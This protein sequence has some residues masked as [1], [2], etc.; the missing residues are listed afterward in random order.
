MRVVV[1]LGGNALEGGAGR[2]SGDGLG[3]AATHVADLVLD[4]HQVIVTH[5]NGPQVGE[6]LLDQ[7]AREP[8]RRRRL[9]LDVL[10]AM[11]QAQLG[12]LLQRDIEDELVSRGDHTDVVTVVTEVVVDEHDPAFV[13]PTKPVGP[14]LGAR[15]AGTHADTRWEDGWWRR[16]VPSPEPVHLVEHA[17]LRAIVED[18]I[19][20]ICAGGGG[21][22]VVRR[23]NRLWGVEAVIDK[24]LTSALVA[25]SLDADALVI[26]TDV[27]HVEIDHGTPRARPL[28]ELTTGDARALLDQL[29]E[30]SM[31]PKVRAALR[32]AEEGRV[33]VIGALDQALDVLAGHAG[34][35]VLPGPP[36]GTVQ[37]ARHP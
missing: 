34:T 2:A 35:R 1:A 32:A 17:A 23:G 33:A 9:P 22:P 37:T 14:R 31:R 20:P 15:P 10:V 36:T 19:V 4:G 16:V 11:T 5:G 13:A 24:D 12:Y 7:D 21:V 29:P 18:G 6:L 26:L 28:E 27:A 25:A 30:G 3:V 8:A